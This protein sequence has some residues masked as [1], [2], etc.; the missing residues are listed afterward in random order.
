MLFARDKSQMCNNLLQFAH[1]YAWGKDHG[2]HTISM[3][4]SYKY[5][6]FHISDTKHVGFLWYF[7]AKYAAALR[8]L[9]TASFKRQNCDHAALEKKMLRH[10]HIVV[11]GWHARFYDSFLRHREEIA[12][13][14]MFRQEIKEKV[15]AFMKQNESNCD[16]KPLRLGIHIRRGDYKEWRKGRYYYDD[17]TYL[18]FIKSFVQ[19]HPSR[20]IHIYICGND[21]ALDKEH[22]RKELRDSNVCF[23]AGNPAEDLCLLSEC[24]YLIGPPSTF[25]L[26]AAMYRDLPLC[27][28]VT[29][30]VHHMQFHKFEELFRDLDTCGDKVYG[31]MP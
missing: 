22:F 8:L 21:P 26:V 18:S 29:K 3:R 17:D 24:N 14:F 4:F 7:F 23:P 20:T 25:S 28:M 1:V 11:S 16:N 2:R 30:D 5:P 15:E 12:S 19:K 27:W 9:P 31:L 10:K 13:L 6:Y